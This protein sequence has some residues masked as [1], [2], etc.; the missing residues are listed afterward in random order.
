MIEVGSYKD[1]GLCKRE[2]GG[3][4]DRVPEGAVTE[5]AESRVTGAQQSRGSQAPPEAGPGPWEPP[6]AEEGPALLASGF[7]FTTLALGF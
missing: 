3:G 6:G 7:D 4:V 5:D 2:A 1:K